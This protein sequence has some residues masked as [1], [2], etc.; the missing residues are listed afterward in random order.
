MNKITPE[1]FALLC[2]LSLMEGG[3]GLLSKAPSYL[4][5][6][7]AILKDGYDAYGWLDI[8]NQRRVLKWCKEWEVEIPEMIEKY[9]EELKKHLGENPEILDLL[10]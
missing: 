3:E 7:V 9:E 4:E 6:K 5:E 2:F 8:W 10:K 1:Q